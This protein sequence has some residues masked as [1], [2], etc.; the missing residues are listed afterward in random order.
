MKTCSEEHHMNCWAPH[1]KG[2][3]CVPGYNQSDAKAQGRVRAQE[4]LYTCHTYTCLYICTFIFKRTLQLAVGLGVHVCKYPPDYI[5]WS[6]PQD[7]CIVLISVKVCYRCVCKTPCFPLS[8]TSTYTHSH[9]LIRS[10]THSYTPYV[11]NPPR[12][13]DEKSVIKFLHVLSQACQWLIKADEGVSCSW[14]VTEI[15]QQ[16]MESGQK[17]TDQ[18]HNHTYRPPQ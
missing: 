18:T 4:T 2:S 15:R 11:W 13:G 7:V 14:H 3:S 1:C 5:L 9:S 10:L 12:H 16:C 17:G 6:H 8:H